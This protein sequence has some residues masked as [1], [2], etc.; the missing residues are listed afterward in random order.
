MNNLLREI[1]SFIWG[2]W[3]LI[4]LLSFAGLYL[5]I[6]LRA[7]PWL[8]CGRSIFMARRKDIGEKP[9]GE[10]D[11]E[12]ALMTAMASTVGTGNIAGV[13]TAIHLGGPGAIFWMWTIAL[14]GM[15]TQYAEATL[16]VHYR[17][18]DRTGSY[19]GGPMY[20]IREGLGK[21]W[22]WLGKCFALFGAIAAFGIGNT[23]Q[24]NSV[25]SVLH[26][27]LDIPVWASGLAMAACIGL[28]TLGGISRIGKFATALV[29]SMAALYLLSGCVILALN[30]EAIPNALALIFQYAFSPAAATG[31]FAGATVL[32]AIQFGLARGIFSN[33]AGLG[34]A[35]IAHAAARSNEPVEQ[36]LLAS[37][38]TFL[39]TLVICTITALTIIVTESWVSDLNGS[40]L[41]SHAFALGLAPLYGNGQHIVGL[42]LCLFALTTLLGWSYYGER[43][44][45]FLFKNPKV[46]T[47][48]RILWMIAIF[49]GAISELDTIWIVADIMNGFMALPNIIALL[50]LTPIVVKLSRDYVHRKTKHRS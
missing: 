36:G 13:A 23:V 34:S 4:P 12:Q 20:Y 15:A 47:P 48:Y 9:H 30:L 10:L 18:K 45:Q 16:A 43:C 11:P 40:A 46:V 28:I 37:L 44:A 26:E 7:M 14:L 3:L 33:E 42:S 50:L 29:P 38:G 31:G 2:P 17:H 32:M 21:R 49:I 39:D 41:T 25:A 19:V 5:T 24:S 1:S 8:W 6:R 22:L 27:N 35:A